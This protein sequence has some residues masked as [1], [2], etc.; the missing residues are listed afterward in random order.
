MDIDVRSL[1]PTLI[2]TTGLWD[3]TD[4][5]HHEAWGDEL[6]WEDGEWSPLWA[7][8]GEED[9]VRMSDAF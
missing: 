8:W 7:T 6:P 3:P 4:G 2:P 5:L 1:T 9:G